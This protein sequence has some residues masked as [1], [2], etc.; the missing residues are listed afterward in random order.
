MDGPMDLVALRLAGEW[1]GF[2]RAGGILL[3]WAAWLGAIAV[4]LGGLAASWGRVERRRRFWCPAAGRDVEVVFEER[5]LPGFRGP[6]R[7]AGCS[8]FEPARAVTCRRVCR[9]TTR[10]PPFAVAPRV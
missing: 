5:R 2:A 7:I 3:A 9:D 1:E 8:A 6:F 10:R 4:A